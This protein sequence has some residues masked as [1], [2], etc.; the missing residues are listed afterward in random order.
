[1]S[2]RYHH[3]P[4]QKRGPHEWSRSP[5]PSVDLE[6]FVADGHGAGDAMCCSVWPLANDFSGSTSGSVSPS[7]A[8]GLAAPRPGR[9]PCTARSIVHGTSGLFGERLRAGSAMSRG[10][11]E[12]Q[13]LAV[14]A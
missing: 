3:T 12:Q 14:V 8:L 11:V 9:P 7:S 4:C 5:R 1:M 13:H 10:L 2:Q 6:A